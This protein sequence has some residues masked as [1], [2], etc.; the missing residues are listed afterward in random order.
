MWGIH[1]EGKKIQISVNTVSIE[2]VM[3]IQKILE[4]GM[5]LIN[6]VER[7]ILI[8]KV[9]YLSGHIC[10]THKIQF[11]YQHSVSLGCIMNQ[12]RLRCYMRTESGIRFPCGWL[13]FALTQAEYF[14]LCTGNAYAKMILGKA[15]RLSSIRFSD[16]FAAPYCIISLIKPYSSSE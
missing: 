7:V 2:T 1:D 14:L 12:G 3:G 5:D 9:F 13:T 11:L 6:S 16:N 4:S 10:F 8:R 15:A